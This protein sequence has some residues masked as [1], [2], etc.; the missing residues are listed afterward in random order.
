MKRILISTIASAILAGIGA[1]SAADMPLKAPPPPVV[2]DPW[3]GFY[4]GLNGGYSWGRS[5]TNAGFFNATTGAA[6]VLPAGV[7]SST[8][9]LNG[10]V[11][12]AQ[13]GYN[14]LNGSFL[15]GIE[16]DIQWSGE[17]GNSNYACIST[18]AGTG[19]TCTTQTA[20]V[21]PAGTAIDAL[22]IQ[23]QIDWFGTLRGRIG[24]VAMQS[25]LFYATGGLAYGEIKTS[26][27]LTGLTAAGLVSTVAGSTTTTKAGWTAGVGVEG[28]INADWSAKAEYLYVDFGTV[29]TALV[30]TLTAPA[31]LGTTSSKVT[32]NIF[33][34]GIN[35]RFH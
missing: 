14:R 12:G 4:V 2:V 15:W 10:G 21:F 8:F 24:L 29:N 18:L 3:T 28:R 23:Q 16:T 19:G 13:A 9:K 25:W 1:A 22:S 11:F 5:E 31:L 26:T 17:K 27:T 35:Y 32:D 30:N 7:T 33:R 34:V 6:V 20:V